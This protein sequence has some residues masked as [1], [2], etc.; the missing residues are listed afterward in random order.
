MMRTIWKIAKLIGLG[1][2]A[3]LVVAIAA[4]L[5]YR[6]YRHAEIAKATAI[7]PVKGIDEGLFT[8]IGGIDQW[9]S[10]RGKNRENPVLLIV[11]GGPG[12]AM[13]FMP[14]PYFFGW[15]S[16]FTVAEWDQ[17][18]AGKTYGKSGPLGAGVTIDRMVEDGVEVAEF[19]RTRMHKRKVVLVGLSWGSMLGVRMALAKPDL[20]HA[21]VGTGQSVNQYKYKRI[22][23]EQ[24]LA[25]A[26][27]RNNAQA[28]KELEAVGPPPYD[29]GSKEGV[30][31]KWATRFEPGQ[32]SMAQGIS[33]VLFES[34]AGP[35]DLRD[36]IRG[37]LSSDEFFRSQQRSVDLPSLGTDFAMPFFVFQGA[38]DNVTPVAPV[39]EYI[40]RIRSPHK[41]LV[42]IPNAG[43]NVIAT[44]SDEFL[45]LLVEKVR[46]LAH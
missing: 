16:E 46:P 45:K 21:Y 39:R 14:R 17:R 26:R 29:S 12:F 3:L 20:F 28:I 13:S 41:D 19:L 40:D 44:R 22:A 37:L 10:I 42:L 36:Y 34:P 43:H 2:L 9:I 27:R 25:E 11:H 4:G 33:L 35:L 1:V 8:R 23:Y 31:T 38:E 32:M 5:G 24:V 7:D 6:A 18:G 30:H 15:T